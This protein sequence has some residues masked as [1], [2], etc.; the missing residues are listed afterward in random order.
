[1]VQINAG[2]TEDV[3]VSL[4]EWRRGRE[5][6]WGGDSGEKILGG[7]GGWA[8]MLRGNATVVS[9]GMRECYADW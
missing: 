8:F 5:G 4:R 9:E 3:K 1:M 6:E 2:R 7:D